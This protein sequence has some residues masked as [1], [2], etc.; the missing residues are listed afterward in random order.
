M[1]KR[2][3]N[4]NKIILILNVHP[5]CISYPKLYPYYPVSLPILQLPISLF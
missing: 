2:Y 3:I 1:R 4:E 5:N